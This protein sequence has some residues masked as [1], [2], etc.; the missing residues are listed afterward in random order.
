MGMDKWFNHKLLLALW[1]LS[2]LE[3]KLIHVSKM[4]PCYYLIVFI[5]YVWE[6][7][8]RHQGPPLLTWFNRD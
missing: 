4:N 8:I 1:L 2:L 7:L 3:L 6:L 5:F